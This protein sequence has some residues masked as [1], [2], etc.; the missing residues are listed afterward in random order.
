MAERPWLRQSD[1]NV[2]FEWGPAGVE[3]VPADAVVVV[4]LLRFTTAIDAAVSRGAVVFPYRWK[5]ESAAEYAASVGAVLADPGDAIGPSLSPVS[6]LSLGAGDRIVLPSPNG[7]TCATIA[8]AMGA[9][10]VAACL[11]NA[12]AIANWL[13]GR[14]TSVTVIACGERWPDGSLRPSLEDFFGAGAVI[15]ALDGS[16]S[17][18]AAAAADAWLA[19]APRI[20]D[21]VSSCASDKEV[22]ERGW[23]RDLEYAVSV[24]ASTCVPVLHE[25]F[26]DANK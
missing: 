13:N 22:V 8:S 12:S 2:R 9:T 14:T 15:A 1:W 4:D 24:D 11:R 16:R 5:D 10:V 7:S 21:A 26:I 17:P 3:A 20:H 23:G 19:A 18:E 25:G 6:L